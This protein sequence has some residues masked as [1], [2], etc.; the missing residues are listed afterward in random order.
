MALACID[1]VETAIFS[2]NSRVVFAQDLSGPGLKALFF[3]PIFQGDESP[4][5]LRNYDLQL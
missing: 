2:L 5:S 4:C 1:D 3:A